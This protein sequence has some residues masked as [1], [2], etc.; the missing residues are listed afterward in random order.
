[1]A[2]LRWSQRRCSG[3][4]FLPLLRFPRNDFDIVAA[5][6]NRC[7]SCDGVLFR[8]QDETRHLLYTLNDVRVQF[9]IKAPGV[10]A[11]IVLDL[12]EEERV[13]SGALR[14]VG[15][16]SGFRQKRLIVFRKRH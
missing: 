11:R 4:R 9:A 7:L 6:N 15:A 13:E 1:M 12:G 2:G 14:A 10:R 16:T 5:R 3:L 8:N